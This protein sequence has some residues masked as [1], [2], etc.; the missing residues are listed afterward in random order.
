M[1][2]FASLY[3]KGNVE[4][5]ELLASLQIAGPAARLLSAR[6][7]SVGKPHFFVEDYGIDPDVAVHFTLDK[8]NSAAARDAL[9][10]AIRHALERMSNDV[11]LMYVDVPVLRRIGHTKEV[12]AG[13]ETF[14][15]AGQ[16]DWVVTSRLGDSGE[17]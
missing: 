15:P 6:M 10:D 7:A 2:L 12:R 16:D 11:L 9:A 5:T 8:Q 3:V 1:S 17:D 4:A 14:A 13:Y